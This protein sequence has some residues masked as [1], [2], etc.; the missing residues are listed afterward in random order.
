LT[1]APPVP[2]ERLAGRASTTARPAHPVALSDYD[3]SLPDGLIARVPLER[4]DASRLL[5]L[6]RRTGAR[7]HRR[8]ADWPGLLRDGDLLVLN[9]A[10]VIPARLL[11]RKRGSGGRVE[12]LLVRPDAETATDAALQGPAGAL[13]W[14][15]LGQ[16]SK[17]L[18]VGAVVELDGGAEATIVGSMGEGELRVRFAAPE[19]LGALVAK[20]GALPLPPYLEREPEE[21]DRVRYQTVYARVAGSVAAPTAG[22]H[23]TEAM[24]A[25]LERRGVQRAF[26]TLDVGPGT[27]LPVR[28]E[29]ESQHR[30]HPERYH[31]PPATTAALARARREGRRV[32][33]VGT[34]VVRTL[35]ST[36]QPDGTLRSGP[37]STTL[38]IRP[39]HRFD[40]VDALL[41][42]FH[43][44]RSTLL[45]LVSAFAGR[46]SVLAAYRDAVEQRYRFFSYGDAMFI[47]E[48]VAG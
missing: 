9:D 21:A 25:D 31:V 39:G 19:S 37:G 13:T 43:L 22:L 14:V 42:N 32:V 45:M 47:A 5:V 23:L 36:V 16:A 6:D 35:E 24:L 41:T 46:E 40:A 29:D 10:R 18:K 33:A 28:G 38:F 15:C 44:P 1:A 20:V 17:G 11:G 2:D 48:G 12:L 26:I 3:Y 8:F 34:T 27:F 4:R 7:L 30:M